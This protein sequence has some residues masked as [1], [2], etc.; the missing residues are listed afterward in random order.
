MFGTLVDVA[1][2]YTR[3]HRPAW[4]AVE[5]KG[6]NGGVRLEIAVLAAIVYY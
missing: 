1:V 2:R 5:V 4:T 6:L 3:G